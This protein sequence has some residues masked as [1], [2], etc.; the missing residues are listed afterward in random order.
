MQMSPLDRPNAQ[1]KKKKKGGQR[2]FLIWASRRGLIGWISGWW[3]T[4]NSNLHLQILID[5][6]V[7]L[8]TKKF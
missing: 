3:S 8:N 1:E 4:Q 7:R 6:Q 5:P 2:D